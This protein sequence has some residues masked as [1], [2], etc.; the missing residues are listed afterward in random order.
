MK[1]YLVARVAFMMGGLFVT[2]GMRSFAETGPSIDS[3]K[4]SLNSIDAVLTGDAGSGEF[5]CDAKTEEGSQADINSIKNEINRYRLL[6]EFYETQLKIDGPLEQRN[7]ELRTY[8]KDVM[9]DPLQKMRENGEIGLSGYRLHDPASDQYRILCEVGEKE[10]PNKDQWLYEAETQLKF[11]QDYLNLAKERFGESGA[12]GACYNTMTAKTYLSYVKKNVEKL[13]ALHK[14][15]QD[16]LD[17]AKKVV[18]ETWV[19]LEEFGIK[20]PHGPV[21][22]IN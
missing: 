13:Q 6:L 19:D 16:A 14:T 3:E 12:P 22:P 4:F 5:Y 8:M 7:K 18:Q 20:I 11:A 15:L 1:R 21:P 9:F 17:K 2:M 10:R